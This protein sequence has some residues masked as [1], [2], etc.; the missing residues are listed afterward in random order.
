VDY[1]TK[2][3]HTQSWSTGDVRPGDAI[4]A[5]SEV[6]SATF[7]PWRLSDKASGSFQA[8][9]KSAGASDMSLIHCM[10]DTNRGHRRRAEIAR[11]PSTWYAI[12]CVLSGQEVITIRDRQITL[13][14]G[15]FLLWDS[16]DVMEY[17]LQ[18]PLEK[19]TLLVPKDRLAAAVPHVRRIIGRPFNHRPGV[20]NLFHSHMRALVTEM[21]RMSSD[22]LQR[23]LAVTLDLL[24]RTTWSGIDGGSD[25]QFLTLMRVKQYMRQ[26]LHDADMS[27][28][29]I[30]DACGLSLR[31]LHTLFHEAGTTVGEWLRLERLEQCRRDLANDR[32]K[33]SITEIAYRW[34]FN[35]A[36]Y[37]SRLF[38]R[39]YGEPPSAVSKRARQAA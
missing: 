19:A 17:A 2:S 33:S 34:G 15:N 6:L 16:E 36:A 4:D 29:K 21:D 26:R 14:A 8:S 11:T 22:E 7:L 20:E 25:S 28:P 9:V 1:A 32:A 18:G 12:L 38:S 13:A 39:V 3:K 30:A 5:W 23:M 31:T 10:C 24:A 35:D 27:P 37:F